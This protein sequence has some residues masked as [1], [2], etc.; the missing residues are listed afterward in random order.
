MTGI[1]GGLLAA[2]VVSAVLFAVLPAVGLL[3]SLILGG[4]AVLL[5]VLLIGLPCLYHRRAD[6]RRAEAA[7][8]RGLGCYA[9]AKDKKGVRS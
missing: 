5:L 9:T 8:L 7:S 4:V 6:V 2:V 3:V 1:S